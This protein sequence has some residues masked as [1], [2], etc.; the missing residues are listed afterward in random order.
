MWNLD[1]EASV[2][3]FLEISESF[4]FQSAV[5]WSVVS[6]WSARS[7]SAKPHLKSDQPCTWRLTFFL[8]TFEFK[9][10]ADYLVTAKMTLGQKPGPKIFSKSLII[11]V[12]L[13]ENLGCCTEIDLQVGWQFLTY[14]FVVNT[15]PLKRMTKALTCLISSFSLSTNCSTVSRSASTLSPKPV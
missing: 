10:Y 4:L 5:H 9:I 12:R 11:L 6:D 13:L 2:Q 15:C 3:T 1:W 8:L 7:C 14:L